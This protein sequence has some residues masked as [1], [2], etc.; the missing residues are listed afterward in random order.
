MAV[1]LKNDE[2]LHINIKYEPQRVIKNS[3]FWSIILQLL[4]KSPKNA[5]KSKGQFQ[6]PGRIVRR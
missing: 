2:Y 6:L 3:S 1:D 5:N 4:Q